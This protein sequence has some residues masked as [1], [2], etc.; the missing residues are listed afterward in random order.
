ML[1]SN[2]RGP[3][4]ACVNDTVDNELP[5]WAGLVL[6]SASP[7]LRGLLESA[8]RLDARLGRICLTASEPALSQIRLAWWRDELSRE[9]P[10]EAQMPPDPLLASL[11]REWGDDRS[12][13]I[14][15]IDGWEEL[16]GDLPPSGAAA[17]GFAAGRE[18][19]FSQIAVS[20]GE[21]AS[22]SD[23]AAHASAWARADLAAF[24]LPSSGS[25]RPLPRLPRSL[26]PLAMI[27][28]LAR[29][30]LQR[31]GK[32]MFGDRFSPLV[33]LRL[34]IFGT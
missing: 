31:G 34:G 14:R 25:I 33:A 2:R 32:A 28:G 18:A 10:A 15:L 20:S 5:E 4:A 19:V 17:V 22:A 6:A 24:G 11:L 16:I 29:R 13:L 27:G 8:L 12:A 7:R 3:E 26:R 23:A 30:A 21:T 1:D 9:R